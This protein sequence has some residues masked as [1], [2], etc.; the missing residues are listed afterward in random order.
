MIMAY[1]QKEIQNAKSII[2]DGIANG[3]SLKS[4]LENNKIPSRNRVYEWLNEKNNK[5]DS[6]FRDNYVRAREESADLDADKIQEI[7]DKTLKKEYGPNEARVAIDA[8]KWS[9]GWHR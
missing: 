8:Y 2:M 3:K 9:A 4:I 6:E 5:Y 7:A 1:T